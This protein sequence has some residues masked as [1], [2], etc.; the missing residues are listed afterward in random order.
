MEQ[1]YFI[2]KPSFSFSL[3]KRDTQTSEEAR[4]RQNVNT[5][6]LFIAKFGNPQCLPKHPQT[7]AAIDSAFLLVEVADRESDVGATVSLLIL[8]DKQT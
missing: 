6:L 3:R 7:F 2:N 1:A 5:S 8:E 4:S